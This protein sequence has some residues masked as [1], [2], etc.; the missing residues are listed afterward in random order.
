MWTPLRPGSTRLGTLRCAREPPAPEPRGGAA[1]AHKVAAGN[2]KSAGRA[3]GLGDG[4]DSGSATGLALR[5][6]G[7]L[8]EQEPRAVEELLSRGADPNLVLVDGAAAV[9]LAAG[10]R[11]PRALLCL[12][13]LLR[14]GGDPNARSDEALTPLHVAAAWGCRRGL[15][16]LLSQG[17]DPELRDQD[18]LRPLDLAMQQGH[19]D[20]AS[21]LR[22]LDTRT[23]TQNRTWTQT[24]AETQKPGTEAARPG[25]SGTRDVTLESTA[26]QTWLGRG[27]SRDMCLEAGLGPPG[28]HASL[29]AVN[30]DGSPASPLECQDCCSDASFVTAVEVSGAEDPAPDTSPCA[31]SWPQT[32]QGLLPGGPRS[33]GAAQLAHETIT[34]GSEAEINACLQ[35]LTLTSSDAASFQ[36]SASSPSLLD[37]SP[38]HSHP[39]KSPPGPSDFCFLADDQTS[40][41][42]DIAALRQEDEASYT[43]G[44]DSVPSC[45]HLQAPAVSDLELLQKLRVL[46]QSPAPITPFTRRYYLQR[47]EETQAAPGPDFSGHSTELAKALQ[48]GHIPDTQAD[49]DALAQQFEQPDP[50]RRW[51]EGMAKSSF[52]YLLLD[53]R[54]TQDLPARAFSLTL[55]E[56]LQTFVRAVFYVGKGTR[57]RP[58]VHLWEA[59]GY[60]GQPAKQP[61][62]TC[63]KVQRILDIWAS[64]RGVISLHCFQHVVAVE[65]YTREACLVD[66]LG[67]QTLTNQKQGHCYGVVA[68][69]SPAR[70]QRLGVHLLHRALRVFLAEGERELRPQDIQAR[71]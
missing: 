13:A 23:K 9:H 1:R 22:K 31:G 24:G 43:G 48:T 25:L 6:R 66:A 34:V 56:C 11:S 47:L 67:I 60:R 53:P 19:G 35:A 68:G 45:C 36:S 5:L 38:A 21:V 61:H 3:M 2:W 69:W 10:A 12:G 32:R 57:A 46:G 33:L 62:Q 40:F 58:Y 59:L 49:E 63:P 44:R 55:A 52:T 26:L 54:E 15:E 37:G 65:A 41:D 51:R 50:A 8:R 28:L 71:G 20:C 14:G 4:P 39:R 17:A 16:L 29:E 42:S 7:A 30:K 70:R 64:G 27:D 18:G